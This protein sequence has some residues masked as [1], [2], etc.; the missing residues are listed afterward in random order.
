[1]LC[2]CWPWLLLA[3]LHALWPQPTYLS[4]LTVHMIHFVLHAGQITLLSVFPINTHL[5]V[6]LK[7]YIWFSPWNP[8]KKQSTFL[9]QLTPPQTLASLHKALLRPGGNHGSPVSAST[10]KEA[11]QRHL[12][13]WMP[14]GNT[15][16]TK[17]KVISF[18]LMGIEISSRE[19]LQERSGIK[20][21]HLPLKPRA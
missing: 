19:D 11:S 18:A 10:A 12:C 5:S 13:V 4:T 2:K 6:I 15:G 21:A 9:N 20:K 1:M 16:S 7:L 14:R 8:W 3:I 17:N